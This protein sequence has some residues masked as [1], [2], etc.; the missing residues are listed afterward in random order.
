MESRGANRANRR[1]AR[2][3]GMIYDVIGAI[4]ERPLSPHAQWPAP[5][6]G[7]KLPA[8]KGRFFIFNPSRAYRRALRLELKLRWQIGAVFGP[9]G[10][11]KSA[12]AGADRI[13]AAPRPVRCGLVR[14][15][16]RGRSSSS[17]IGLAS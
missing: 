11:N 1:V 17:S 5:R 10:A 13:G 16:S 8:R 12:R 2:M 3:T 7:D 14:A 4:V 15:T 6:G 9:A